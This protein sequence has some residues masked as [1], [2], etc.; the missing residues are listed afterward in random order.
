[1]WLDG[2]FASPCT[3]TG[4]PGTASLTPSSCL[5]HRAGI[6]YNRGTVRRTY[7]HRQE[8]RALTTHA[9]SPAPTTFGTPIMDIPSTGCGANACLLITR[10]KWWRLHS[11]HGWGQFR[12]STAG[13]GSRWG[14]SQAAVAVDILRELSPAVGGGPDSS[15][16]C[17]SVPVVPRTK[18]RSRVSAWSCRRERLQLWTTHLG[19]M[20]SF[21]TE[22]RVSLAD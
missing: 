11:V 5:E 14:S 17:R 3:L 21:S 1:M 15:F 6:R 8:H 18:A 9:R 22:R 13:V 4:V 10:R 7:R 2:N 19:N 16:E 12:L 20:T